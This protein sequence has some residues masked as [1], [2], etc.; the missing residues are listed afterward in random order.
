MEVTLSEQNAVPLIVLSATRDPVESINSILRRAGHPV[1]CTWIPSLR[2]LGDAL[3]QINPEL[4]LFIDTGADELS[5]ATTVRDQLAPSVPII[6][7]AVGFDESRI[8]VEMAHG[9]RDVV[10]LGNAARLQAVMSRELRSFRLER[11]LETTLKSAKDARRQLETVLER[12]NDAIVQV[13]EGIIVDANPSWLELFGIVAADGLVGQPIM[14]LF[15]ESKHAALKGALAACLQGRWSDHTLQLNG[16]LADGTMLPLEMVLTPGEHD[17]E[18]CV[19]MV[20]PARP[21]DQSSLANDL[22]DA[23]RRDASTGF[24]Y[25]GPLLEALKERLATPAPGGVRYVAI[26]RPDKFAAIE[27]D[28]G[29][30]ASETV[31][32][33]FAK[34]LKEHL[35]AKDIAGRFGG[36]GFLVLL[37]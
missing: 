15:E 29:A 19:R 26:V 33:E 21:K 27:H 36:V 14:D 32:V 5:G 25:R 10:S 23:V 2:D 22:E 37:E 4:L 7:V 31:L 30:V 24:L 11:A 28:V 18:P 35:N 20:V 13:Q 34:L 17:G 3:A 6:V 16:I 1:H 12:S 9:A 8:A